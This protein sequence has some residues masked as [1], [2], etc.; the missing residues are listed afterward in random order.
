[1]KRTSMRTVAKLVVATVVLSGVAVPAE[2]ATVRLPEC[3]NSWYGGKVKPRKWDRGCTGFLDLTGSRWSR[4][5]ESVAYGRGYAITASGQVPVRIRARRI[6][7]CETDTWLGTFYTR[8][9][10]KYGA[11]RGRS[12]PLICA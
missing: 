6:R 9:W 5:G 4:W 7:V 12:Y 10:I 11:Q 2:G 3:G 8:V 1:M